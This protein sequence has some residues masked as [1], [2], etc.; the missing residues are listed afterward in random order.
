MKGYFLSSFVLCVQIQLSY[1]SGGFLVTL[2][3]RISVSI[4]IARKSSCSSIPAPRTQYSR[5]LFSSKNIV[6]SHK[7]NTNIFLSINIFISLKILTIYVSWLGRV[8]DTIIS[9]VL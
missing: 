4:Y 7:Y 6:S 5:V 8:A 1:T 3:S 2:K 9:E